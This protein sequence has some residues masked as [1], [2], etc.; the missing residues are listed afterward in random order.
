KYGVSVYLREVALAATDMTFRLLRE[1][2][3]EPEEDQQAELARV[4]SN[5]GV[6][7]SLLGRLEEALS[8]TYEAVEIYRKLARTEAF[9]P[10]L[11]G[12]LS[13]LGNTLSNLSSLEDALSATHE[14][15]GIY[16]KL[17]HSRPDAFLF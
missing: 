15:V 12:S 3:P 10:N 11:A 13:N 7:L 8:T 5:L 1:Q 6:R 16:R 2:W 9:L 17:A 4:A 14:A